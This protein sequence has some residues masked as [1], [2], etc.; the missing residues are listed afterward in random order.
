MSL[1]SLL[2]VLFLVGVGLYLLEL[3]TIIDPTIKRI[4]Q[5][6]AIAVVVVWLFEAFFGTIKL[7]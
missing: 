4:I 3:V 2:L 5:V 7:H 6:V 1:A